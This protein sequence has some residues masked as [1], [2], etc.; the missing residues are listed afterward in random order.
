MTAPQTRE[1]LLSDEDVA[2]V[3]ALV[4][5][6]DSVELKL[7]VPE[8]DQR[9]VVT[10]L[11]MDPLDAQIRQVF[12]FDT[13][14]LALSEHGVVVRARRVQQKGDDSVVKLRPVVPDELPGVARRS[15]AFGVE[16]DA[17]PGGFVCSASMKGAPT[18]V[19]EAMA[20]KRP[21]RKLFSKEQ[22][23]FFAEHAPEGLGLDDLSVLGPIF[24]L[25]LK[26]APPELGRSWSPSCGCTPTARGSSSSR[27]SAP[28]RRR[29]R[30][31]PRPGRSWRAGRRPQRRAADQDPQGP[32]V[33]L[34]AA[35]GAV[36]GE[37]PEEPSV[38]PP[39]ADGAAGAA[40]EAHC[41]ECSP[42]QWIDRGPAPRRDVRRSFE[43][44]PGGVTQ[45]TRDRGREQAAL[46]FS[47]A[48]VAPPLAVAK[49]AAPA[50]RSG[51]VRPAANP[52]GARRKR[53]IRLHPGRLSGGLRDVDCGSPLVREP[54]APR[55]PG[56]DPGA[57][58]RGGARGCSD[59]SALTCRFASASTASSATAS[60]VRSRV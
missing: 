5:D 56:R 22:R 19:R 39:E 48:A 14:D 29:S 33:L 27:R 11:G 36:E 59:F 43:N 49:L 3:I 47:R 46:S 41:D 15:P 23:A 40:G 25:K 30:S 21:L 34:P 10:A 6:V 38:A 55:S 20:G 24:V 2:R 1:R 12:F 50:L 7:S 54:Q 58:E 60:A 37:R 31:P 9:A 51:V 28:R 32:G 17:M 52:A 26:F 13:P 42:A 4:K 16:V 18:G 8:A 45:P 35:E 53:R 57:P 44:I